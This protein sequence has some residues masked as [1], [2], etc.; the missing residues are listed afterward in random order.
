MHL[1]ATQHRGNLLI[2]K[3]K[4]QPMTTLG[5]PISITNGKNKPIGKTTFKM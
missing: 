5:I 4:K 2:E 1:I 3:K